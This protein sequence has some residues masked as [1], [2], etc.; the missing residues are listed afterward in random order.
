MIDA[1]CAHYGLDRAVMAIPKPVKT[2][3]SEKHKDEKI[4][5]GGT[6]GKDRRQISAHKTN[7]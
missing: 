6:D 5:K 1:V 2:G 4:T 3:K 7:S